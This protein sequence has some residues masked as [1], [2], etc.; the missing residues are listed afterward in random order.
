MNS[1]LL[2]ALI[3]VG[4]GLLAAVAAVWL[5]SQSQAVLQ[6]LKQ[7]HEESLRFL[8]ERMSTEQVRSVSALEQR[9][10]AVESAVARL[11]EQLKRHESLVKGFEADRE[12]KFGS[13]E[14]GLARAMEETVKLRQTTS[15]LVSVLGNVKVRGQWGQKMAE[16]IL[17]LC[18]LQP[19]IQYEA[20][21]QIGAVR[22]DYTFFLP[23][24]QRLFMDVKFPFENYLRF[25]RSDQAQDQENAREAFVR[26]VRVHLRD[27]E[28]RDYASPGQ[29]ALDYILIFIPNEQVYGLVNEWMPDLFDECLKKRMIVCGPWTL[30]A[31]LS[32]IRQ[33]WEN[34]RFG[35]SLQEI[36]EAI[37]AFRQDYGLFNER[38]QEVGKRIA[39]VQEAYEDVAKTSHKRLEQKMDKIEA[40][41]KGQA[42]AEPA[43]SEALAAQEN[44]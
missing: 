35:E 17:R 13:L 30:Y 29:E 43:L 22:P 44:A 26:D 28:K 9:K 8:T 25:T 36:V 2:G 27:M 37:R 39:R 20:E 7:S 21:K 40:Y 3:V 23:G 18:G 32:I 1:I 16:D 12:R 42:I 34:Y 41:R 10:Q 24:G 6:Q 11:E 19:G 5:R 33:A 31:V 4:M 15:S 38:F 14:S